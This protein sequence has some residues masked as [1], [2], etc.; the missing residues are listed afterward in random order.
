MP[1]LR[2]APAETTV[3]FVLIVGIIGQL[4]TLAVVTPFYGFLT[5]LLVAPIGGALAALAAAIFLS[6]R[7]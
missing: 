4:V 7:A 6:L 2:Y 3:I 5:A 1:S